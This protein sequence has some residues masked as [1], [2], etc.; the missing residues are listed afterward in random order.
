M[1]S[2]LNTTELANLHFMV[3]TREQK[4]ERPKQSRI[5]YKLVA[6]AAADD[7]GRLTPPAATGVEQNRLFPFLFDW[8]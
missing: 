4:L 5:P 8:V 6:S 3:I 7:P 1:L 2:Y